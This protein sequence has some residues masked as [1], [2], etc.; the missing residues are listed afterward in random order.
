MT[1]LTLPKIEVD[2]SGLK[3]IHIPVEPHWWPLPVGWWLV[4]GAIV[5]GIFTAICFFIYWYTRPKQY[6]LRELKTYYRQEKN[7]V[8]LARSISL[9]LKRIA[10]LNYP[11]AEVATLSDES[12]ILFLKEKTGDSFLKN[13]LE[14]LAFATY[15]PENVL[16]PVDTDLLYQSARKGISS[17][18]DEVKHE[19]KSGKSA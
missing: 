4:I 1:D 14:L 17:L 19:Y 8:L 3:D 13:Q 5:L 7:P 18:F 15:M 10:L 16:K 6:A 9:L 11:R 2:L 12:W